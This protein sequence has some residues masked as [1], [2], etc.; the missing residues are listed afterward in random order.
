MQ[1]KL[2]NQLN[3]FNLFLFIISASLF[4]QENSNNF[5]I[6]SL[7]Q[8]Y[9][10]DFPGIS[11]AVIKNGEIIENQNFGL[12]NLNEKLKSKNNTNYRLASVT[13]Q[14]TALAIL[15][16]IDDK[17]LSF[18]TPLT[19]IFKDFPKYG[20]EITIQ[21]LLTHTSGLL[22]YENLMKDDRTDPILD[23][24]VLQL[25]KE[26]KTTKFPPG[27]KYDY[28][29]SAYA[30]LAQVIAKLSGKSYKEFIETEIFKPLKMKKSVVYTKDSKIKNRA[31][32]YTIKNN[33]AVFSDQSMTSSVQGDGGIYTSLNDYYKWDQA[34]EN[35]L[36][37]PSKLLNKAYSIQSEIPESEWDYGYGWRIK[38][39]GETKIVSHSGHTSG[40]TNYVVKIPDQRLTIVLFSNR[41]N[42]DT[43]I[44]IGDLLFKKYGKIK[45]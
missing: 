24:E 15:M 3:N 22:D 37:I 25:M 20:K 6:D 5:K 27:S 10:N 45:I 34:L 32:G 17:K 14:F 33:T 4:A 43:V 7:F 42:D 21:Q 35:N 1:T 9:S 28:S 13:K 16:L 36:L 40:F 31:F 30:V 23:A 18:S 44:K 8:N 19:E 11:Y 26:Q 41:K 38:Y 39:D 29:N 2:R 12:G